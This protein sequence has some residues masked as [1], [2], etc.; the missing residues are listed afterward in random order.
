MLR[1]LKDITKH[2][3]LLASDGDI[4]KVRDFFFN[5]IFWIIKYL[6]ADTGDW[7][8]ERLVLISPVTLGKPDWES[9][10]LPVKL[11]KD[12]IEN[13]PPVEKHRPVSWQKESELMKY[14]SLPMDA[15]PGIGS[16]Q[17][18]EMI[19]LQE[20]IK[21]SNNKKKKEEA[22]DGHLRS[23][24]EVTGY[25]IEATDGTIGHV[26]DFIIED[27]SWIIHYIVV[28]TKSWFTGQ[29]V[30]VSPNWINKVDWANSKVYINMDTESIK[31]S[32]EFDPSDPVNKNFEVQLYDY[33]GKPQ[34]V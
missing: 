5:D 27:K 20:R 33:L 19:L 10:L 21:N 7:L 26:D 32:P 6:V 8:R 9:K 4:G 11:T 29:K 30:L 18:T 24:E 16:I 14:Y 34:S 12:K 1:S 25:D 13:S 15:A 22:K 2:Y 28:N 3:N 31:N 17:S 23:A